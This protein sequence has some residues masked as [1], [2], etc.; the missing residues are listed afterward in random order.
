MRKLLYPLVAVLA[1]VGIALGGVS[2]AAASTHPAITNPISHTQVIT[3]NGESGYY[4]F[5]DSH[6][7]RVQGRFTATVAAEGLGSGG[8]EGL[9]LCNASSGSAD[10]LGVV[11]DAGTGAY[12]VQYATGT[13]T[14]TGG[15]DTSACT[16][17]GVLSSPSDIGLSIPPGDTV[18]LSITNEGHGLAE[19][20]AEDSTVDTGIVKAF[21]SGTTYP[22]VASAGV[23]QNEAG[24]SAPAVNP[25]V[26]FRDVR[27]TVASGASNTLGRGRTRWTA[28]QAY[29]TANGTA[30]DPA[31]VSPGNSLDAGHFTISIGAETGV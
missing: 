8:G 31:L 1:A 7:Q 18:A 21:A 15:T 13:L 22:D 11:W 10:Q 16:S 19:F 23:V 26:T 24:L 14:S 29:S 12:D 28:V 9:Q 25:L 4:A 6:F 27:V 3:G 5:A 30:S 17:G 2:A 20:R